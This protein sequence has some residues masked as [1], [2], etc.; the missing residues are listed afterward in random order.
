MT[1]EQQAFDI[2]VA[3]HRLLR[4]LRHAV[5]NNSLQPSQV[6][7]LSQLVAYGPMRV[8]ELAARVPCS[9]PTATVAVT[10]LESTGY[11]RREADPADGRAIRVDATDEGRAVLI[12]L[13]QGEARELT[14][15]LST[16]D[17]DELEILDR[18]APLL[19][20]LATPTE[21]LSPDARSG[22]ATG[23]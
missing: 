2:V 16:L 11:V 19:T 22:L 6:L 17:Q 3:L 7:V 12:S 14:A 13:A 1:T 9:Q 10:S 23:A 20:K 5:R 8:G 4:T 21:S 15:R 18:L